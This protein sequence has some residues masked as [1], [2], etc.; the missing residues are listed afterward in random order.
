MFIL[1]VKQNIIRKAVNNRMNDDDVD[2]NSKENRIEIFVFRY[3]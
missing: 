1:K 3:Q 2:N